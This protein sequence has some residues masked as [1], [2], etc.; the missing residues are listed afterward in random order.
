[1]FIPALPFC[2]VRIKA[3]KPKSRKYPKELKT[4]G[5]HIRKKRLDLGLLQAEVAERVG[6]TA[7]TIFNWER[8]RV[9]PQAR[10][11]RKIIRFL[12][13]KPLC[14]NKGLTSAVK[15]HPDTPPEQPGGLLR[16]KFIRHQA[17]PRNWFFYHPIC[18]I[19]LFDAF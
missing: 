10:H 1:M 2:H 14:L 8:N 16:Q 4:L 9:S 19:N 15:S 17:I 6:V 13:Y 12:G 18:T 3:E 5:D 7:S 11:I